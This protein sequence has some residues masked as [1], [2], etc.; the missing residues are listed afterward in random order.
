MTVT[1]S[2]L[3]E[4]YTQTL[5]SWEQARQR[6]AEKQ[7]AEKAALEARAIELLDQD[8]NRWPLLRKLLGLQG[9]PT[10]HEKQA[11][12]QGQTQINDLP[13]I[14]TATLEVPLFPAARPYTVITLRG[15]EA[16]GVIECFKFGVEVAE[17]EIAGYVGGLCARWMEAHAQAEID[18]EEK[19][20]AYAAQLAIARQ[21]SEVAQQYEQAYTDYL[22][23]SDIWAKGEAQR[24][25]EPHTLWRVRYPALVSEPI[26]ETSEA[27][28]ATAVCME[29]PDDIVNELHRSTTATI[30]VVSPQGEVV[31]R[32][33]VGL[34]DAEPM[35]QVAHSFHE[36]MPYH[37]CY[38]AVRAG[39]MVN[40]PAHELAQPSRPPEFPSWSKFL[41]VHAPKLDERWEEE[42]PAF[43]LGLA[44]E[45]IVEWGWELNQ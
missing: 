20:R 17:H 9:K 43:L 25:W 19:E 11:I 15:R 41:T 5:T 10:I 35:H 45:Q 1:V 18:R 23:K 6:Q 16:K 21:V 38:K 26:D 39:V 36:P 29:T 3:T 28:L 7:A 8:L 4:L 2:T 22:A 44:P 24:L 40:V 42:D 14:V 37:R 34:L 13:V 32:Q 31:E 12:L 30:T 33:I 27:Y